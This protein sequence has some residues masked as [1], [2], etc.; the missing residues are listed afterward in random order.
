MKEKG[1]TKKKK[2]EQ[3]LYIIYTDNAK[4]NVLWRGVRQ[5]NNQ[6]P[7]M[8]PPPLAF[9][10]KAACC[11]LAVGFSAVLLFGCLQSLT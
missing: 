10:H 3:M 5:G 8:I 4:A 1:G 11:R 6:P 7:P 9:E 2:N